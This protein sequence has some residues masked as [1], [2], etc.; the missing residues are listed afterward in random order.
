MTCLDPLSAPFSRVWTRC[1][2]CRFRQASNYEDRTF[3]RGAGGGEPL[4]AS[5]GGLTSPRRESWAPS[6]AYR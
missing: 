3:L 6:L 4:R 1:V 5:G 2:L